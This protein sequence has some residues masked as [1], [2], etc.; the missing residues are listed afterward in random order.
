MHIPVIPHPCENRHAIRGMTSWRPFLRL[1]QRLP[2]KKPRLSNSWIRDSVKC[3]AFPFVQ[4][5]LSLCVPTHVA[6]LGVFMYF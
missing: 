4:P 1:M 5:V 2:L 3:V 6:E